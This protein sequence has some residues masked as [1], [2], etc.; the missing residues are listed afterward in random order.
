MYDAHREAGKHTEALQVCQTALNIWQDDPTFLK[1]TADI[2]QD[3]GEP[4]KVKKY[5]HMILTQT[6]PNDDD[7]LLIKAYLYREAKDY[8]KAI[9][10]LK[11]VMNG[12]GKTEHARTDLGILYME[13]GKYIEAEKVF[14]KNLTVEP[15]DTVNAYNIACAVA[16]QGDKKNMLYYLKRAIEID[17]ENKYDA[18]KE[19][20]FQ[21]FQEDPD[22]LALL[23]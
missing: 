3:L 8:K 13:M 12:Y 7:G 19:E 18:A 14:H 15:Y 16:R 10:C 4:E 5:H 20:D 23:H 17:I 22:F 6:R 1:N 21:A 11:K 9:K 2:Y